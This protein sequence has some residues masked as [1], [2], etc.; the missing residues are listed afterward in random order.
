MKIPSNMRVL[1]LQGRHPPGAL[2]LHACLVEAGWHVDLLRDSDEAYTY[3]A[4]SQHAVVLLDFPEPTG[5]ELEKRICARF[6]DLSTDVAIIVASPSCDV[7]FKIAMF[8]CGADDFLT[9]PFDPREVIAR[10]AAHARRRTR[11]EMRL[12]RQGVPVRLNFEKGLVETPGGNVRLS[13]TEVQILRCF[14]AIGDGTLSISDVSTMV[15]GRK[16]ET[17]RNLVHK[18]LS[19]LR[20]KLREVGVSNPLVK[21]LDGYTLCG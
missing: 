9:K 13:R 18:H 10:A 4:N 5:D 14:D 3:F 6:R 21:K 1:V 12:R 16:D 2:E 19:N 20:A 15:F 8:E 11:V 7:G 17:V